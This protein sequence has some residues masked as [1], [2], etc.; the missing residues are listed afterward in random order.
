[1]KIWKLAVLALHC[2]LA[3]LHAQSVVT[4]TP[5]ASPSA[6]QPG[7][8][9]VTLIGAG[10]PSGTI[11]PQDVAVTLTAV[12]SGPAPATF[13]ASTV[14]PLFG[15]TES[16]TFTIPAGTFVVASPTPCQVS[17]AGATTASATFTSGN[18][19]SLTVNP[20]ATVTVAPNTGNI[21]QS[22]QVTL[23]GLYTNFLQGSTVASFG[24]YIAVGGAALGQ[25]GPVTVTSATTATA[26]LAIGNAAVSGPQ[27]VQVA[28]GIQIEAGSFTINPPAL[29]IT[30][31]SPLPTGT[32]GVNYSTT[33]MASGG[34]GIYTWAV[35]V[36]SL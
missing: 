26:E 14:Q 18:S 3:A 17:I 13:A 22:E 4:L 9:T 16:V 34:S 23:T 2:G 20:A 25:P 12:S 1:M 19:A 31:S 33:L 29:A 35:S 7:V 5:V 11:L 10:F 27:L 28:T 32:V 6:A 36:G 8:T 15:S 24:P 30:T 21:G